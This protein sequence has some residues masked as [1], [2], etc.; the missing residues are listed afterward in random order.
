MSAAS[1]FSVV[2]KMDDI[3]AGASQHKIT[4]DAAARSALA[5]RFLLLSLSELSA[6]LSLSKTA[7]GI[8]AKGRIKA[9][10]EQSCIATGD[11]VPAIIDE[12]MEVLFVAE[13]DQDGEYE[14]DA[15][16]CDSMFHDGKG[17]D[18]GEAAAHTFG[19]ALDPYPRCANAEKLLR[20]AGVKSEDEEKALSGPFAGLA[21]LKD[22]MTP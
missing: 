5:E 2:I 1:E 16:A 13:P 17:V 4:A 11:P 8:L 9:R 3:G 22:K 12:P 14:L 20:K 19:L 10:A 15:D 6:E 7:Q 18:I 21:A